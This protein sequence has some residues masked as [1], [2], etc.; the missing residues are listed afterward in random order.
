MALWGTVQKYPV[1]SA[2]TRFADGLLGI[3]T[4]TVKPSVFLKRVTRVRVRLPNLDTAHNRVPLPRY[5]FL[6]ILYSSYLFGNDHCVTRDTTEYGSASTRTSLLRLS[7]SSHP[8]SRNYVSYSSIYSELINT[9]Y[10]GQ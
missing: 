7:L 8:T 4:G 5:L 6:Q 3:A 9:S 1:C 2:G 10:L